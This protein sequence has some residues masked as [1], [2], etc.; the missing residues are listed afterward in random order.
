[1][2]RRKR[3]E[4][5]FHPQQSTQ[6]MFKCSKKRNHPFAGLALVLAENW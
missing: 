6:I 2:L 1:M 5:K 3:K 4:A